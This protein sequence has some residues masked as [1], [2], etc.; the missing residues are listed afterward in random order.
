MSDEAWRR[1]E[2][3]RRDTGFSLSKIDRWVREGKIEKTN[4]PDETGQ[5]HP[6]FRLTHHVDAPVSHAA[7][8]AALRDALSRIERLEGEQSILQSRLASL[9]G[10]QREIAASTHDAPHDAL[11]VD[12]ASP[13][14]VAWWRRL[15]LIDGV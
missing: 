7:L 10:V 11:A 5:V 9:E 14:R 8:L 2:A 13:R 4:I 1:T 15:F 12:A 3:F 6:H